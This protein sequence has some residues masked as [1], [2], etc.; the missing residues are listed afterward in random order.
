[1]PTAALHGPCFANSPEPYPG[2]RMMRECYASGLGQF[3]GRQLGNF[4]V[5]EED[6]RD[7]DSPSRW[8]AQETYKGLIQISLSGLRF[9]VF[10]N[11]GAA[12]AT[13]R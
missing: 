9:A 10:A 13:I 4:V 5:G 3:T 11:G 7:S 2:A 8:H 1:M 12:V 6:M